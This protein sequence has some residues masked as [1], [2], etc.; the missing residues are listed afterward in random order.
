MGWAG[1]V[2]LLRRGEAYTGFRWGNLRERHCWG[3]RGV[4]REDN[5]KKD[6]QEVE[7]WPGLSWLSI[8]T[9]GGQ[10]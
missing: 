10:F 7:L 1:L 4:E 8:E 3:N 6:L 5:I 2:A 9:G